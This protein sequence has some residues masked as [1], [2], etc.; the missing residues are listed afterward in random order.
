MQSGATVGVSK[1]VPDMAQQTQR[2]SAKTVEKTKRPGY[3]CDGAGLY[4][5]VSPSESKRKSKS[6]ILR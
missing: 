2:L 1:G 4:L 6:W 5:Q 3:Y